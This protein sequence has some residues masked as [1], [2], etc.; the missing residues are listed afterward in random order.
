MN[1]L[2]DDVR[3]LRNEDS[4]MG[5]KAMLE[6][7]RATHANVTAK[8]VREAV[9]ALKAETCECKLEVK[10]TCSGRAKPFHLI[11]MRYP[12]DERQRHNC[13]HPLIIVDRDPP[14]ET[15]GEQLEFQELLQQ[16]LDIS[17]NKEVQ[18]MLLGVTRDRAP[19]RP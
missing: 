16:Q 2:L 17:F 5:I 4:E 10:N 3:G 13:R 1:T 9:A 19:T 12:L 8:R 14:T 15:N 11:S 18:S 7:L 6:R